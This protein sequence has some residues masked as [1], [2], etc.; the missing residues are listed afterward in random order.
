MKQ[1]NLIISKH[2]QLVISELKSYALVFLGAIILALAYSVFIVPYN[3]MPGGIFGL[4]IILHEYI[5]LSIG[6]IAL[7]INIPLLLWGTK[8]LGNKIGFKTSFLM[9][10]VSFLLD[11]MTFIL[12]DKIIIEDVLISSVFGGV[13]IGVA[14]ALVK[15]AGATT[16]GNDILVRMISKKVKMKFS[17]LILIINA[18][19]IL[20]GVVVFQNYTVAAYSVISIIAMSKTVDYFINKNEENK[21]LFVFS[22]NNL[23]IQEKIAENRILGNETVKFIYHDSETK[24]ILITKNNKRLD[25]IEELIYSADANAHIV[26]LNSK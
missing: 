22:K 20:I 5:G 2:K 6:A 26:T 1:V 21:T 18:I 3:I 8:M 9:I 25:R 10:A 16:G 24:M 13:L 17:Q 7:L 23:A 4:S 15:Y 12:Q 19:V 14:I 11:L